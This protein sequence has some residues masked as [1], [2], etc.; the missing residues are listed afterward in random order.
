MAAPT[1]LLSPVQLEA[2]QFL[3][4]GGGSP[5]AVICAQTAA[6][7][8]TLVGLIRLGIITWR[9]A[10][11]RDPLYHL[12]DLGRKLVCAHV[13]VADA[14]DPTDERSTTMTTIEDTTV[15]DVTGTPDAPQPAKKAEPSP[16]QPL[17][18]DLVKA[19]KAHVKAGKPK[20]EEKAAYTRISAHGRAVAYV[21]LPSKKAVRVEIPAV[22]SGK[23]DV[24]KITTADEFPKV[25]ELVDGHV[26]RL[27][28]KAAAKA[29][30]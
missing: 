10:G 5:R 19:V 15:E 25:L 7:P 1:V 3:C 4:L 13:D 6:K 23:Y 8:S 28:A 30:A 29:A 18:K 12:T 17:F 16:L 26:A 27:Q 21:N 22:E 20:V 24:V 11:G 9:H 14:D 2:A